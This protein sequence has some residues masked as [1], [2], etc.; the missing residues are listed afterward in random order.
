MIWKRQIP[1]LIVAVI[2][3]LTLFGWLI[4][5]TN[6]ESLTMV[7]LKFLLVLFGLHDSQLL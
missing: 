1:N 3:E 2:G 6:I 5:K 7:K 4:E